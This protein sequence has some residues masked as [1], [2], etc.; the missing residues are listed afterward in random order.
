MIRGMTQT[1]T[2]IGVNA[3]TAP[4]SAIV[5]RGLVKR[6]G[7]VTAVAGIDLDVAKGEIFGFLGPNGAGKST[8]IAILCTL[9][10]A[11]S[12]EVEVAGL[13]AVSYTHLTL[14]TNR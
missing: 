10:K 6:Y 9:L 5:V 13:D 8:T 12:G 3:A 4:A 1:A 11:T 2:G 14:P 7:V